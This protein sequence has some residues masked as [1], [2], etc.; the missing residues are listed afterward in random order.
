MAYKK[1]PVS[2]VFLINWLLAFILFLLPLQRAF[3]LGRTKRLFFEH[4]FCFLRFSHITSLL[5]NDWGDDDTTI[6]KG[7]PWKVVRCLSTQKRRPEKRQKKPG[8]RPGELN[9]EVSR[10]GDVGPEGP[11]A[12]EALTEKVIRLFNPPMQEIFS[13]IS[14]LNWIQSTHY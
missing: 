3:F 10:L 14:F 11:S 4:L 8:Q 13:Y 6:I 5:M 2:G 1:D 7:S 12:Q 9:R